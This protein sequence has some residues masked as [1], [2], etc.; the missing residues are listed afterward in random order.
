MYRTPIPSKKDIKRNWYLLDATGL[1]LG[2]LATVAARILSGKAKVTYTPNMD[3][4][5]FLVII[6]AGEIKLSKKKKEQKLYRHHTGFPGGMRKQSLKDLFEK[7]PAE[8]IRRAVLGMIKQNKL[9]KEIKKR[10]KVYKGSEHRHT[11]KLEMLEI[12]K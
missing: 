8:V 10:L 1:R 5:D 12:K 6:N 4:G 7:N 3:S 9:K 11:A 2:R